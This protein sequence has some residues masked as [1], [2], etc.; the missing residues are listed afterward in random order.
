MAANGKLLSMNAGNE[1]T[2]TAVKLMQKSKSNFFYVV[3]KNIESSIPTGKKKVSTI[4]ISFSLIVITMNITLFLDDLPTSFLIRNSLIIY[5]RV[6][7]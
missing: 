6:D 5:S 2:P 1:T 7:L 4:N 3:H